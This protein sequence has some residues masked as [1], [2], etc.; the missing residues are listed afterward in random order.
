MV[1]GIIEVVCIICLSFSINQILELEN[2]QPSL[3]TTVTVISARFLQDK[4]LRLGTTQYLKRKGK[5]NRY[6]SR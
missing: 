6:F 3:M 2:T 5:T 1:S 4:S